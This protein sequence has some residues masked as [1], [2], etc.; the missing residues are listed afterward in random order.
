MYAYTCVKTKDRCL[1]SLFFET[2]SLYIAIDVLELYV[3]QAGLE[4]TEVY[5]CL[6]VLGLKACA[7]TSGLDFQVFVSLF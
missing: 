2:R 5:F 1:V 7:T 3:D 6:S 4:L